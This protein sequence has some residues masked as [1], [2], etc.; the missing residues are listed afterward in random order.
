MA[1]TRKIEYQRK[2]RIANRDKFRTYDLKYKFGL[3]PEQYSEMLTKQQGK[4]AG[5]LTTNPGKNRKF[6]CIDHCHLTG[7]IRALLCTACNMVLGKVK[8]DVLTLKRLI[9][10][11]QW[12]ELNDQWQVPEVLSVEKQE[13]EG[14]LEFMMMMLGE[15]F[16]SMVL[17]GTTQKKDGSRAPGRKKGT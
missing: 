16:Q 8:D 5:C 7:H 1:S 4:C 11:L 6:F 15:N 2:Y 13:G 17:G 10:I 14:K 12:R 9:K 3:S